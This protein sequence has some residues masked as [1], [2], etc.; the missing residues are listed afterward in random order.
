M[1]RT[2]VPSA[3]SSGAFRVSLDIAAVGAARGLACG[4]GEA[5]ARALLR[6]LQQGRGRLLYLPFSIRVRSD[7]VPELVI[8]PSTSVQQDW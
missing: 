8:S 7:G 2:S 3:C 5:P 4:A 6:L 1:L